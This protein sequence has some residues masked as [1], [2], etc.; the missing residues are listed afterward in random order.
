[1]AWIAVVLFDEAV[2]GCL[3]VPD[4]VEDAM[5]QPAAGQFCE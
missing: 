4:G 5:L 1:M 3:Q 2:D